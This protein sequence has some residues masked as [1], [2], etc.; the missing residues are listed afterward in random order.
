VFLSKIEQHNEDLRRASARQAREGI[1]PQHEA[2][3]AG[4]AADEDEHQGQGEADVTKAYRDAYPF[5]PEHI[6][7]VQVDPG[8]FRRGPVRDGHGALSPGHGPPLS[9]PVQ[10]AGSYADGGCP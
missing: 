4:L 7:P 8:D 6:Q 9:F 2:A 10:P 1:T 5:S 3:I